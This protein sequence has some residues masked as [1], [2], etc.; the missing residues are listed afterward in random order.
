[1]TDPQIKTLLKDCSVSLVGGVL[2]IGVFF[3][4]LVSAFEGFPRRKIMG[5]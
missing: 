3:C 4:A 1:M 2:V 5:A